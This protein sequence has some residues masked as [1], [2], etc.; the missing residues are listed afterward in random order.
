ML[1][2]AIVSVAAFADL[3][4][5]SLYLQAVRYK[6]KN[7]PDSAFV[8]LQQSLQTDST[9][10]AALYELSKYYL[11]KKQENK[12]LEVLQKAVDYSPD[13][14]EYQHELADLYRTLG[15]E[16]DAIALYEKLVK[17]NP[18]NLEFYYYLSHLYL[19]QNDP[20]HAIQALDGLE[21][22]W[23]INESVSLQK[24]QLYK[25]INRQPEALQEIEKLAKKFP[26]ESKYSLLLGDYY[27]EENKPGIAYSYYEKAAVIDPEDP[28][29]SI[30]L[31]NYYRATG[32]N[33]AAKEQLQLVV[34]AM[35]DEI[36]VWT[37]LL[38]IVLK[39][40]NP[41]EI[42]AICDSALVNFPDVPMFYFY[43][44]TA[45]YMKKDYNNALTTFR[46]GMEITPEEN[47]TLLSTFSGQ[48][49]DIEYLL[50]HKKEAYTEYDKSLQYN[51]KN[52]MVLNNY[53]YQLAVDKI[54]LDKAERMAATAV[55]LQ[56]TPNNLDTYA[57]V[58]F[59]KGNYSLAKFYIESAIAK[60]PDPNSELLEHYGDILFKLGNVDSAVEEWKL[61]LMLKEDKQE[62]TKLL[63]KKIENKAYYEK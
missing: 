55:H 4:S 23:G 13:N 14:W 31:A 33:T 19:Q 38:E 61:A 32:N 24:Y 6:L 25:A 9:S 5:D 60:E 48:I 52:V 41:D 63:K 20:I 51:N 7:Q 15:K 47:V 11:F 49:A 27:M 39:E 2:L 50:G 18:Q 44:G 16:K 37:Q 30:A 57:W 56:P 59:Q 58:F 35:P 54:H 43:E 28:N 10:S 40:E 29:I 17:K 22:N 12:S 42:I 21:N 36:S 45:Y 34:E 62:N 46:D 3:Q 26:A 1:G 8:A 53:A